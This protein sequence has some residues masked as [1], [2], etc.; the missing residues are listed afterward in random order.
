[1]RMTAAPTIMM[2]LVDIPQAVLYSLMMM[3]DRVF[4]P[5][6]YPFTI[7]R[8]YH[9]FSMTDRCN[10]PHRLRKEYQT[11]VKSASI[12]PV[13]YW[14]PLGEYRQWGEYLLYVLT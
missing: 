9:E 14:Y 7:P 12:V 1:M 3:L 6:E 2:N 10:V 5:D 13:N 4:G 8:C 11:S